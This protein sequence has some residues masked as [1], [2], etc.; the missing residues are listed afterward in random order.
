VLIFCGS[1]TSMP[2][3]SC[4]PG[5][6]KISLG[7]F[8]GTVKLLHFHYAELCRGLMGRRG[9]CHVFLVC[10]KKLLVKRSFGIKSS[11]AGSSNSSAPFTRK[12]SW[13]A[14]GRYCSSDSAS[15]SKAL[16]RSSSVCRPR[17]CPTVEIV[18][19]LSPRCFFPAAFA[20]VDKRLVHQLEV[21]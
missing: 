9:C 14:S 18:F 19:L 4:S 17:S 5:V 21:A 11:L 6:S 10:L 3:M 7:N 1:P 15:D 16:S 8:V 13:F 12:C 2:P 20:H